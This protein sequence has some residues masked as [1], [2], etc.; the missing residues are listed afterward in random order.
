[1]SEPIVYQS[2][3][4]NAIAPAKERLVLVDPILEDPVTGLIFLKSLKQERLPGMVI[5]GTRTFINLFR[6]KIEAVDPRT[7]ET[8]VQALRTLLKDLEVIT[9]FAQGSLKPFWKQKTA[10]AP[11]ARNAPSAPSPAPE[12]VAKALLAEYRPLAS[13]LGLKGS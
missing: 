1:M 2:L 8:L 5:S 3:Y 13:L 12:S 7:E 11:L 6:R 10:P 4:F 9:V